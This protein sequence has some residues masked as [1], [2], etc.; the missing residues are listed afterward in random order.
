MIGLK[1]KPRLDRLS[2]DDVN[3][4]GRA[5]GWRFIEFDGDQY[6]VDAHPMSSFE[7]T[8]PL[9]DN[10]IRITAKAV[11]FELGTRM[12]YTE[13]HR[14]L[15]ASPGAFEKA[16]AK[17]PKRQA[18]RPRIVDAIT[19]VAMFA[20]VLEKVTPLPVKG[21]DVQAALEAVPGSEVR[22]ITG[23]AMPAQKSKTGAIITPSQGA[24]PSRDVGSP[25]RARPRWR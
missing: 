17:A 2:W 3:E 20:R 12:D 22:D 7:L 6:T 24:V 11:R 1:K 10:E 18:A 21:P 16:S 9:A 19:R 5:G 15:R 25:T 8:L 4:L 14:A 13:V 23:L